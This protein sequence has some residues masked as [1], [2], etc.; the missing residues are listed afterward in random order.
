MDA[1]EASGH[2]QYEYPIPAVAVPS[3]GVKIVGLVAVRNVD[4][5]IAAFLRILASICGTGFCFTHTYMS[6]VSVIRFYTFVFI[7]F[8][9]FVCLT[10]VRSD[11]FM[12]ILFDFSGQ[13]Q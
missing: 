1:A 6:H 3:S 4:D 13:K 11:F 9:V 7:F 12:Y 2:I 5:N 8:I 10:V